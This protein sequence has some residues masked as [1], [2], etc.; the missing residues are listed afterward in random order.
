MLR[1]E[2]DWTTLVYRHTY[3]CQRDQNIQKK[4]QKPALQDKELVTIV[5]Q[6][7]KDLREKKAARRQELQS[8]MEITTVREKVQRRKNP[9]K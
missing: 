5:V 7:I 8:Y 2:K 1:E 3:P 9:K 6:T 4:L